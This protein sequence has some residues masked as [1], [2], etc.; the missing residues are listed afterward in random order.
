MIIAKYFAHIDLRLHYLVFIF[1]SSSKM[2]SEM[3]AINLLTDIHIPQNNK[4]DTRILYSVHTS[5]GLRSPLIMRNV[6]VN[7]GFIALK[8]NDLCFYKL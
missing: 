8:N 5:K 1:F 4:L 3:E 2:I 6:F 7:N